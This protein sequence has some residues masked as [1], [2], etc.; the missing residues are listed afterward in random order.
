MILDVL[1]GTL[2]SI[3]FTCFLLSY[4]VA[5]CVI[6]K[7]GRIG[8]VSLIAAALLSALGFWEEGALDFGSEWH[9]A[10]G[11]IPFAILPIILWGIALGVFVAS[12]TLWLSSTISRFLGWPI[13]LA[14]CAYFG[15]I[16]LDG[17]IRAEIRKNE[18]E[19]RQ[20]AIVRADLWG[21][22]SGHEIVVPGY[23]RLE[24]EHNCGP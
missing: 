9:T 4:A 8:L 2:S 6:R 10:I 11:Y 3:A 16:M 19:E 21:T 20:H 1:L 13:G 7:S 18:F 12:T 24:L 17:P 22:L 23:P 14:A 5:L 15:V